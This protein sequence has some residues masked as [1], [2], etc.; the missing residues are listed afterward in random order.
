M[1]IETVSEQKRLRA[2]TTA[3]SKADEILMTGK[4]ICDQTY[5]SCEITL[6]RLT[7]VKR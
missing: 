1:V 5:V 7:I 2:C 6:F 4:K 3:Q